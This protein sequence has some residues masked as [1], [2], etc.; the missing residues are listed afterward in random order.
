MM[1][2]SLKQGYAS[3]WKPDKA[4]DKA[5]IEALQTIG[6]DADSGVKGRQELEAQQLKFVMEA[7]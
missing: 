7:V 5:M 6:K 4:R 2:T 1:S 3:R